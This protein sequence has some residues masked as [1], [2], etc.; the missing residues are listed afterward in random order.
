MSDIQGTVFNIQRYSIDD[1]P[2]IRTTVFMKGCP[3]RCLWC[4]NPESQN[5]KPELT[6]RYTSCVKCG[7]CVDACPNKA[8][9]LGA[10]GIQVDRERCACCGDCVKTCTAEAL[11]ISGKEMTIEEVFKTIKRDDVYYE[12]SDGGVTA[13]GGEILGQADFV[14][15]L[16]KKCHEAGYHTNA[17]TSGYGS[18][19]GLLKILEH[20]DLV[21][22]DL[23]H[24][25]PEKHQEAIG[26][27]NDVILKNLSI[28]AKSGVRVVIRF[29]L[30]PDYNDTA[31][32]LTA[33]AQFITDL[34]PEMTI[35]ILPYHRYGESKYA[36]IGKTY[37]L[38]ELR[39]NS[40]E[41]LERVKNM[42]ESFG[43]NCEISK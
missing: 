34:N 32:N 23:K 2:G 25:D 12:T 10:G 13:S 40:P 29:P 37:P 30:I 9:T 4:S 5:A 26:I 20:S 6:Y 17:D 38:S 18:E 28:A 33:M 19:E 3:L 11:Q 35:H 21:Y 31:E 39:E 41:D 27:S 15:A 7:A 14:A 1:G 16:F 36:M 43:L 22:F 24:M 8:L 42:F